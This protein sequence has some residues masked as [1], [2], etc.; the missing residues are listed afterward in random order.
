M[1]LIKY[2]KIVISMDK[3]TYS[4]SFIILFSL[5][6]EISIDMSP[7]LSANITSFH[8]HLQSLMLTVSNISF[9]N[10]LYQKKWDSLV[11]KSQTEMN[12]CKNSIYKT[13]HAFNATIQKAPVTILSKRIL[14]LMHWIHLLM[15]RDYY[16]YVSMLPQ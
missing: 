2:P 8:C 4:R 7:R 11:D 3:Y 13:Q 15:W 9:L 14:E 1:L 5:V 12:W 10:E 6:I 16:N